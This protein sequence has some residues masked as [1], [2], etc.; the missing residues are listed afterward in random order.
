MRRAMLLLAVASQS[1]AQDLVI[2]QT[3]GPRSCPPEEQTADGLYMGIHYVGTIDK[4][5][6]TGVP[7]KEFDSNLGRKDIHGRLDQPAQ[8]KVGGSSQIECFRRG[9]SGLCVGAKV[10]LVC[11]PEHAYGEKGGKGGEIPGGATLNFDVEIVWV[12]KKSRDPRKLRADL[13]SE[14]GH[15]NKFAQIDA[16]ENGELTWDEC[17]A[18]SKIQ[19]RPVT[20][21]F[22]TRE[23]RDGD[24]VISWMEFTG[25]KGMYPPGDPRVKE[26]KIKVVGKAEL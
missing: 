22:F 17:T 12:D 25:A 9:L 5:S 21:K 14:K 23:D 15:N 6:A 26:E 2:K 24:G 11:P 10:S 18:W 7:G 8:M 16:D 3:S 13:A 4:S 1:T 20:E 19:G